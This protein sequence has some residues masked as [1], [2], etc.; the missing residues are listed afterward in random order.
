M[1]SVMS[2]RRRS[3]GAYN[4]TNETPGWPSTGAETIFRISL[5]RIVALLFAHGKTTVRRKMNRDTASKRQL[6]QQRLTHNAI[7]NACRLDGQ[8]HR[9]RMHRASAVGE[10]RSLFTVRVWKRACHS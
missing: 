9:H 10:R 5:V 6:R 4:V 8:R 7:G 3:E 2:A 1:N